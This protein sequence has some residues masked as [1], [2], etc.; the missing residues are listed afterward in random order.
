MIEFESTTTE[1][2]FKYEPEMIDRTWVWR[3]LQQNNEVRISRVF[4]FELG[5][6]ITQPVANQDFDDYVYDFKFGTLNDDYVI[7]PARILGINNDLHIS[8][9]ITLNRGIFAAERNTSIFGR[10]SG[11]LDH[12]SPIVI[13][14]TASGAIPWLVFSELLRKFPNTHELN[15]YAD[16]RVH[17]ILAQYLD[18]MK[19]ARGRYDAYLQRKATHNVVN[20]DLEEIKKLEVEKY[21]L[22]R[23]LIKDALR[24]KLNWVERDW[25][26]LM[27]TFLLLLFPKYIRVLENVTIHDYYSNPVKKTDRY[28]DIALVDANGNIDVIEIKK[29]FEDKILRKGEYRGNSIPTAELSGSIMQAEK[30]LFHLS[31]WGIKGEQALTKRYESMLPPGMSIHISNP[32]AIIIVGRDQIGD[33]DMTPQQQLDFEVIKRKYA[34][35]MDIITYDDLLRRL[36]NTILALEK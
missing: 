18:G 26:D 27:I 25:Q 6:L 33:A 11:L 7:I 8:K 2:V 30:Y 13:G 35:M 4:W 28:I 34:N 3:E 1:I 21:V 17:T 16:A 15:R 22:I 12:T 20:L 9:D 10:L 31:K 32:K 5:D 36:D 29:P 24:N 19:D 14:G 23:N